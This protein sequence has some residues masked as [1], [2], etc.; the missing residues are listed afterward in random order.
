MLRHHGST[1]HSK[2][3]AP[4][5]HHQENL[6]EELD[7]GATRQVQKPRPKPQMPVPRHP[8]PPVRTKV[9]I[10]P[11]GKK[12]RIPIKR[13]RLNNHSSFNAGNFLS[14]LQNGKSLDPENPDL[15]RNVP[16]RPPGLARRF[17]PS[18]MGL[19]AKKLAKSG[20]H[21]PLPKRRVVS[22]SD[23]EDFEDISN[24][25][26]KQPD[27][28][29]SSEDYQSV[30]I[31]SLNR[32]QLEALNL[33]PKTST[34]SMLTHSTT[35]ARTTTTRKS[36]TTH[37]TPSANAVK[38]IPV[39]PSCKIRPFLYQH[40]RASRPNVVKRILEKYTRKHDELKPNA[41]YLEDTIGGY[42]GPYLDQYSK[43]D[44]KKG[45]S[46]LSEF[47]WNTE[48]FNQIFE[49]LGNSHLKIAMIYNPLNQWLDNFNTY[50][51]QKPVND[52]ANNLECTGLPYD[53]I[54]NGQRPKVDDLVD[55]VKMVQSKED[56]K[57]KNYAFRALNPQS[58]NMNLQWFDWSGDSWN[59]LVDRVEEFDV[60]LLYERLVESLILLKH[61]LCMK[62][63][64]ILIPKSLF[65]KDGKSKT[66]R[67]YTI[68]EYPPDYKRP[69]SYERVAV[70]G[71][72]WN[73][74]NLQWIVEKEFIWNDLRLYEY[75][76]IKFHKQLQEFGEERM[77]Q[78]L[79]AYKEAIYSSDENDLNY[80]SRRSL[81]DLDDS[82][83][84]NHAKFG[85]HSEELSA[86]MK[87]NS[88]WCPYYDTI[89]V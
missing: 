38:P 35:T 5:H 58:F 30:S 66:A 71:T 32:T 55:F 85:D 78:E 59:K 21:V 69:A 39:D 41:K 14:A 61:K 60:V 8:A 17:K 19:A 77:K 34:E 82:G 16:T 37:R 57:W 89:F 4:H 23:Y 73:Y 43:K 15:H 49:Q 62:T 36:T 1:G 3:K 22:E 81:P 67:T 65:E 80:R 63:E 76:G 10:L 52:F 44:L 11:N 12:L 45:K 72:F 6:E 46:I 24:K 51:A 88:G 75:A 86:Y 56:V 20:K 28:Y 26:K 42:P 47:R 40:T 84:I 27:L 33:L 74:D 83:K 87:S 31:E 70:K 54:T 9:A 13:R 64:D 7:F 53:E 29:R 18:V 25:P 50:Y 48:E 79:L 68:D 2:K